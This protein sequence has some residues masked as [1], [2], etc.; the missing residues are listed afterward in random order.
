MKRILALGILLTGAGAAASTFVGNGGNVGD[1]ELQV[2]INQVQATFAKLA[3]KPV[4]KVKTEDDDEDAPAPPPELCVCPAEFQGRPW[5]ELLKKLNPE[6]VRFCAAYIREKAPELATLLA[7]KERVK[8][9]WTHEGIDVREGAILRGADAVTD[10]ATLTMTL[11]QP[12]Y[13]EMN[14]VDRVFLMS[15]EVFHLTRYEDRPLTDEGDVGPFK[16]SDGGRQLI[17]AMAASVVMQASA[18]DLFDKYRGA[19]HRSRGYKKFWLSGG[20]LLSSTAKDSTSAYYLDQHTGGRIGFRYQLTDGLGI[21]AEYSASQ[22]EKTLVSSVKGKENKNIFSAGLAYR[23]FLFQNPLTFAGQSHFILNAKADFLNGTYKL[24]D[25]WVGLEDHASG[26]G[27]SVEV[28]YF[29]PF[30]VGLWGFGGIGYSAQS[31]KYDQLGLE[32]KNAAVTF[33]TGVSYGF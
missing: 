33:N 4:V 5:C 28:Q 8:F 16:G 6:Q 14:D 18:Y 26:R 17:N 24:S 12:R 32:Y 25:P 31:Y 9:L 3:E 20:L 1:V 7:Q 11:N 19:I 15:H 22:G 2:T 21:L 30:A 27:Y 23:W 13:L 29:I 10:P